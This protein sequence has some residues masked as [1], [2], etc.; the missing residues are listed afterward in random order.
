MAQAVVEHLN[1]DTGIWVEG[2]C[3]SPARPAEL[4]PRAQSIVRTNVFGVAAAEC[5]FC[6]MSTSQCMH[7]AI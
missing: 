4:A 7:A 1:I 5:K 6:M 2:S 3:V